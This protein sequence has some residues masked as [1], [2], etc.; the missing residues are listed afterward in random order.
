MELPD[1]GVI[2]RAS[3]NTGAVDLPRETKDVLTHTHYSWS[4]GRFRAADVA[5]AGR[6][7]PDLRRQ[8]V[9]GLSQRLVPACVSPGGIAE[10]NSLTRAFPPSAGSRQHADPHR[11]RDPAVYPPS[12]LA[13]DEAAT[14]NVTFMSVRCSWLRFSR[15]QSVVRTG[16]VRFSGRERNRRQRL[17]LRRLDPLELVQFIPDSSLPVGD[18]RRL[19]GLF[20][21]RGCFGYALVDY[22]ILCDAVCH[23][24][25]RRHLGPWFRHF[26]RWAF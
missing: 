19:P 5:G 11:D 3:K 24:F 8:L 14:F 7:H 15:F 21:W 22:T 16:S 9:G 26:F 10:S 1:Q 18:F 12:N 2:R 20:L 13:G 23:A 6:N 4:R 25:G 17:T